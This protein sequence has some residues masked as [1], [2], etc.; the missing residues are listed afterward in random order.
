VVT[1]E[2]LYRDVDP[3][4]GWATYSATAGLILCA[5]LGATEI[6][7]YG[8]DWADDAPD[9]DGHQDPE[10]RRKAT[11]WSEESEYWNKAVRFLAGNGVTVER[12]LP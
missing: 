6:R 11:R 9:W 1:C 7:V 8:A 3:S 5:W 4:P 12:V 2:D 10:N